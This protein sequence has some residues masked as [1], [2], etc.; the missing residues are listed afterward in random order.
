MEASAAAVPASG[1]GVTSDQGQG[2]VKSGR[3]ARFLDALWAGEED[4]T[5]LGVARVA[6]VAVF[7]ASLLTHVGAVGDYFSD[8]SMI[9]GEWARQAFKSRWSLFFW[10]PDPTAVR[11]LFAVGVVA[12]V[13]W[14]VGLYTRVAAV[15]AAVI[16]ISMV[17]RN[18]LLYSMPDNMHT[19]MLVLLA[20]MPAGR[21][22]SLDARWR[23]K[24]G[25]VPVWCRRILQLQVAAV[26]TATGLL[27]SGATWL[28]DG[29]AIYYSLANPYNRHFDVMP[30]LA[31]LQPYVLRPATWAVL[32]W[33]VGFAGFTSALWLREM[34]NRRVFPD[35]R[36][37]F[38]GFGVLM[39][40][41]IQ[42]MM[43]VAWFT[44]LALA[45]YTAFVRPDEARRILGR[46]RRPARAQGASP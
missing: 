41:G 20:T 7:T 14:L 9:M 21:G 27:K 8:E 31:S 30:W 32:I 4:P 35:M 18:P 43:Y 3:F 19:C 23:G 2:A 1:Q 29:T 15:V 38:L 13:L 42:A 36:R 17:G 5:A 12:H 46:V 25:P 45:S 33:E 16:W 22:V 28:H 24:G 11:V 44:P 39:H 26:Y 37:L 34:T 10:L 40:L 6:L